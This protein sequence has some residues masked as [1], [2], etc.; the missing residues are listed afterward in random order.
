M[1]GHFFGKL[2]VPSS[3]LYL[4]KETKKLS[5]FLKHCLINHCT[6]GTS[7]NWYN[8][9]FHL[10]NE[11]MSY[12]PMLVKTRSKH[13]Q[14]FVKGLFQDIGTKEVMRMFKLCAIKSF[15]VVCI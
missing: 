10:K 12:R 14:H 8:D 15:C 7:T 4:K 3:L 9:L 11:D 1:H 13:T 2:D 5:G 6:S